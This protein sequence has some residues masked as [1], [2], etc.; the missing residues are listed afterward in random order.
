MQ[1]FIHKKSQ[2]T[3]IRIR[4]KKTALP[5]VKFETF[6]SHFHHRS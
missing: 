3:K 6:P 4:D 2:K 5:P 1:N